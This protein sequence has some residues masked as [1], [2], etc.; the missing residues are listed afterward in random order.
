MERVIL[1]D[2][3]GTL[4]DPKEG[5]TRAVQYTL[6]SRGI[7]EQD[8]DKLC[9]FIG[10]PLTDSYQRFY[11]LTEQEA[12][13][14]IPVFHEYFDRQGKF[15]NRVYDGMEQ[16]LQRLRDAGLR[17]AV[18]TSKPEYFAEQ[19]LEHFG[20]REYFELVGG[21]DMEEIRVRKGE[22]I[23]YTLERLGVM[24]FLSHEK[25][26][27]PADVIMV[28]DREHD[29]LGAKENGLP[30]VGVLYGYGSEEELLAAGA[31]YLAASPEEL[32]GLLL[33]WGKEKE[34]LIGTARC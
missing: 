11:G 2:L 31:K 20:L 1:F 24:P 18:S 23:A 34:A 29:V 8:L 17:L 15:E 27:H 25:G 16:M 26:G 4:T 28:G 32:G 21:A 14:L 13:D 9:P 30:C 33:K 5:I 7:E 19:I 12:R 3:D 10:P 6:R 22:I